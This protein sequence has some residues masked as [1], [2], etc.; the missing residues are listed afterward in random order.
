M[1]FKKDK[2]TEYFDKLVKDYSYKFDFS[3]FDYTGSKNKSIIICKKCEYEYPTTPSNIRMESGC[4]NCLRLSKIDKTKYNYLNTNITPIWETYTTYNSPCDF[5]CTNNHIFKSS[6]KY[7]TKDSMCVICRQISKIETDKKVIKYTNIDEIVVK[8]NTC[9]ELTS[10][11]YRNLTYK[12]YRCNNCKLISEKKEFIETSKE[13][14][15]DTEYDYTHVVWISKK[16]KVNIVCQN[17]G[18]FSQLPHNHMS[19]QGCPVCRSSKGEREIFRYLKNN[20]IDFIKEKTFKD[21]GKFRYDFY[22]PILNMCIEYDGEHHFSPER[23]GA[24]KNEYLKTVKSDKIKDQYCIDN[25][26]EM[27]RIPY[28]DFDNIA[29]I[30][31]VNLDIQ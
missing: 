31:S 22:L 24:D 10:D 12:K 7:L 1:H 18:V 29:D 20:N 9:R 11:N 28:T 8:C 4:P 15:I 5:K 3:K 26:I 17:H 6:L 2:N 21:L 30:L 23:F 25:G 16:S 27:L 19:G 13:I 14:H